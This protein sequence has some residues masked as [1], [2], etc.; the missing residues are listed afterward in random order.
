MTLGI[1]SPATEGGEPKLFDHPFVMA[2]TMFF[3]EC[4]CLLWFRA[5][6]AFCSR[7]RSQASR[8]KRLGKH[9]PFSAFALPACCDLVGTSV[10]YVGLTLTSA[11][12]YQML[13][14]SSIIFTV[15]CKRRP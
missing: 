10:M 13:R 8:D 14:G 2:G 1:R 9:L 15:C 4:L 6:E 3:G 5:R 7:P 12:T 11:S